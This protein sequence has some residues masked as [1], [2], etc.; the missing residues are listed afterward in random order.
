VTTETPG[1][2]VLNENCTGPNEACREAHSAGRPV[3]VIPGFRDPF[4][5]PA[6]VMPTYHYATADEGL[7]AVANALKTAPTVKTDKDL[8]AY[9]EAGVP[10]FLPVGWKDPSRRVKPQPEESEPQVIVF[11]AD[12][13]AAL[14]RKEGIRCLVW[15]SGGGTATICA[16][17]EY[18][19]AEGISR[20]PILVGPGIYGWGE[21]PSEFYS[22][23]LYLGP[24]DDGEADPVDVIAAGC[25]TE[26]EI[27]DLIIASVRKAEAR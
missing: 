7:T 24:D 26:R 11:D 17:E 9:R 15:Q 2:M 19:D 3:H 5:Q 13:I 23:E 20:S 10:H 18:L 22:S 12:A 21:R 8:F 4:K 6:L 16:G 1:P 27:A 25:N 14:V